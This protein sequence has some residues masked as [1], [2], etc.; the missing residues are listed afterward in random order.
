M[1][2]PTEI[3]A[4]VDRIKERQ[5]DYLSDLDAI[6]GQAVDHW[7]LVHDIEATEQYK[8][9]RPDILA[10]ARIAR[11]ILTATI[12]EDGELSLL[13]HDLIYRWVEQAALEGM[14]Q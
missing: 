2:T 10:P 6:Y 12:A 8:A 13:N 7:T 5:G 14:Q 3:F 4:G 11:G 9:E 1:L